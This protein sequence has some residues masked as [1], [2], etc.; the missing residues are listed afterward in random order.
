MKVSFFIAGTIALFA[1]V[2]F[3]RTNTL[4]KMDED[5][6]NPFQMF[7]AVCVD[8]PKYIDRRIPNIKMTPE[9]VISPDVGLQ[10]TFASATWRV[11]YQEVCDSD[12]SR[13]FV[14]LQA[15]IQ[16]FIPKVLQ[17][18]NAKINAN[19]PVVADFS[20]DLDPN[21][22]YFSGCQDVS[23][24]DWLR[25]I[26]N[27]DEHYIHASPGFPTAERAIRGQIW[28]AFPALLSN[29]Q[30]VAPFN[31]T[32]S[33]ASGRARINVEEGGKV[34]FFDATIAQF[35]PEVAKLARGNEGENGIIVLNFSSLKISP[36]R[37]LGSLTV[38]E[39][40][41][42]EEVVIEMI[43]DPGLYYFTFQGGDTAPEAFTAIR[44]QVYPYNAA[45]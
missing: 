2:A 40:G 1:D 4:R 7:D 29:D 32:V 12:V 10:Y 36:G 39:L 34:I 25:M 37:F 20:S 19:G 22:P 15:D 33:G 38:D 11:G 28:Q 26:R 41:V 44:G 8:G 14:C 13:F 6:V 24:D 27:P 18:S 43:A 42:S 9:N 21:D 31:E 5:V 16:G 3:C 35:D 30:T 45:F 23:E 17:I